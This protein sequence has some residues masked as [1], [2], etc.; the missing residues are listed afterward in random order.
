VKRFRTILT[1]ALLLAACLPAAALDRKAFSITQCKLQIDLDQTHHALAA[2]GAIEVRNNSPQPQI[3]LVLQISSSLEWK[4]V[5]IG[6]NEVEWLSDLYTSDID[7]TGALTEIVIQLP[8]A[9]PQGG[10]VTLG[11]SYGGPIEASAERLVRIGTPVKTAL[12]SDWDRL[13]D[14]FSAMRGIG[15]VVWYPVETDAASLSNGTEVFD[16]LAAWKPRQAQMEVTFRWP[17]GEEKSAGMNLVTNGEQ[18]GTAEGQTKGLRSASVVFPAGEVPVV[19]FGPLISLPREK[20]VVFHSEPHTQ[21][22]RDYALA[23]EKDVPIIEEWFGGLK[24]KVVIVELADPDALPFESGAFLF[25]PLQPLPDLALET[26]LARVTT[27]AAFSSPRPWISDGLAAF[28]QALVRER[29]AGRRAALN[30]LNEFADALVSADRPGQK[31]DPAEDAPTLTAQPLTQTHDDLFFRTKAAFVWWMLRDMV[32]DENLR[33]ALR[34]YNGMNDHEPGY[35]QRLI[36]SRLEAGR[37]LEQFF[38]DWVY[39]DRGLPDFAIA[40][41]NTRQTLGGEYVIAV[42]VENLGDPW[43]EVP[44]VLRAP[45]G[46][47][48]QRVV[49]PG[50]G[51]A[52]VRISFHGLPEKVVVNDGSVPESD[53]SNNAATIEAPA[54]TKPHEDLPNPPS[55]HRK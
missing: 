20:L 53:V 8:E 29:Q 38:D 1:A 7:H 4:R 12:R 33:A 32:G 6:E 22:A 52:I 27:H 16:T 24:R 23:L 3:S 15:Y 19:V 2:T 30:Y 10:T 48:S 54:P 50:H 5:T 47:R 41:V 37:S 28:A 42:T 51:K 35:M 11:V 46:E 31:A 39:R 45:A 17:A 34:S 49:V 9:I 21:V 36:E 40:A 44:V 14:D 25:T 13:S 55:K 43:C 18:R 26:A